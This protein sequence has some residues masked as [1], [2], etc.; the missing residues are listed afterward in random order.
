MRGKRQFLTLTIVGLL[1]TGGVATATQ[2]DN[3]EETVVTHS[4]NTA[5]IASPTAAPLFLTLPTTTT[6]VPP[7]PPSVPVARPV[8]H[9]RPTTPDTLVAASVAPLKTSPSGAG[10]DWDHVAD[11]ESGEH[12][13]DGSPIRG[14]ANW[15]LAS[16]NGYYGGLQFSSSTW[17]QAGGHQFAP[18]ANQASREQQIQI[19]NS[20]LDRTSWHQW[21]ICGKYL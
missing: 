14:T 9:P 6:T 11:C 5:A 4:Y 18:Q 13:K 15:S 7:A 16:G 21:P 20:W 19:A 1:L 8:H 2:L 3:T 10:R 12:Y 17:A